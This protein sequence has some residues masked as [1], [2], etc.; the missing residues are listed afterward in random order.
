MLM[1]INPE[2]P[3]LHEEIYSFHIFKPIY[4]G[5][6]DLYKVMILYSVWKWPG[7]MLHI[8]SLASNFM[9]RQIML[10]IILSLRID[11]ELV[12]KSAM[13]NPVYD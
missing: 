7:I 6:K 12:D 8:V 13:V 10:L 9:Q 1:L 11:S 5:E 3:H 2:N 4:Y